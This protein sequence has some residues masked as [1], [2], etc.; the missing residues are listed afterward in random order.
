MNSKFDYNFVFIFSIYDYWNA[1][2]GDEVI[3]HPQVKFYKRS[4]NGNKFL[5]KLFKIHWAYKLNSFINLPFKSIWFKKMYEQNF[6]NDLPICFVFLSPSYL[7][8]DGGFAKY[9]KKRNPLNK[10]VAYH[11]DLIS[12]KCDY[13]YD[14]IRNKADLSVTYDK[15]E[16]QKYNIHYFRET[17]YSKLILEPNNVIFEN[18]VYFLGAAKDRLNKIY[19]IFDFLTEN[20]LKCKFQLAGVEKQFQKNVEGIEYIDS[21]SYEENLKNVIK[22]KCVLEITQGGSSDI[23]LRT[24]EA[25]A[26]RRKLLTDCA[27]CEE[28]FFNKNQLQKFT[29]STD[30]DIEFIKEDYSPDDFNPVVNLSP[31]TRL[32][33]IQQALE[34]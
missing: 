21:V 16:S 2:L 10:I 6:N 11:S 32:Y 29:K 25:I 23:T 5:Q 31:F 26:Y 34:K 7:R 17:V 20:N 12:K 30:I 24:R 1:I 18:D 15:A 14:I 3:N 4:F 22:S 33:D 27:L 9:I 19:E 8:F 13:N 28:S